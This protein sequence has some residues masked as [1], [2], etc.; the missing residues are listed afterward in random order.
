[1][2]YV[3]EKESMKGIHNKDQEWRN[4]MKRTLVLGASAVLVAVLGF[5]IPNALAMN[6]NGSGPPGYHWQH[7]YEQS[8]CPWYGY[9]QGRD[10][11]R[12]R[13]GSEAVVQNQDMMRYTNHYA[14]WEDGHRHAFHNGMFQGENRQ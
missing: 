4:N 6:C 2:P 11:M 5:G 8:Y 13:G 9:G 14:G 3:D 10:W 12:S 7:Q 1:L